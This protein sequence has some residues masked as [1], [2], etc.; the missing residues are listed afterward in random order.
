MNLFNP[1]DIPEVAPP[2]RAEDPAEVFRRAVRR[3]SAARSAAGTNQSL[4]IDPATGISQQNALASAGNAL[5]AQ[6]V[7]PPTISTQMF[8]R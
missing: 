4:T 7:T 5:P 2:P 8:P 1:P 3:A 6:V